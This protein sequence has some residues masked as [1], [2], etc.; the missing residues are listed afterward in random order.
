MDE[1]IAITYVGRLPGYTVALGSRTYE[2]EWKKSL[3][4]GTRQDEVLP[5]DAA[6]LSRMKDRRGKRL[7]YL[8][9]RSAIL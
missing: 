1:Y 8:D 5:S 3:G 2:F 7:F 6:S 9:K 4:I